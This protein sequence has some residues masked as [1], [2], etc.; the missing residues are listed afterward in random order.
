VLVVSGITRD[1]PQPAIA[2]SPKHMTMHSKLRIR[3][4]RNPSSPG[5][6]T[7]NHT[8]GWRRPNPLGRRNHAE[9]VAIVTVTTVVPPNTA[10]AGLTTQVVF[11]GAPEQVN[12]A[13][14][15]T[16]E[17]DVS[18]SPYTAC[19][20]AFTVCDVDPLAARTKS[21]PTPLSCTICGEFAELS[22]IVTV[23]D[24]TPPAV[25]VNTICIVHAEP[26]AS[27]DPHEFVPAAIAKSPV[28]AMFW[29]VR[30][31]P[32]LLV[33]VT[34]CAVA[35]VPTPVAA[36]GIIDTGET[37][38][39]AGAMPVPLIATICVRYASEI[40]KTPVCAPTLFGT[41]ATCIAQVEWPFK[42]FP[43]LF[44]TVK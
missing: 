19:D 25:G 43:Q 30:G 22:V 38:T 33:S 27:V 10:E 36:N 8:P 2:I 15:G 18:S 42:E 24:R 26:T 41:N 12:A 34:V 16:P 44:T 29:I 3:L 14:P 7:A 21:T 4:L 37:D 31:I 39:P 40:V 28:T 6:N 20:P 11:A 23:P 1:A 9:F 5:S 35:L 17:A 32:P 13:A